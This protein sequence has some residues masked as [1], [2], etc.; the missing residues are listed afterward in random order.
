M[1]LILEDDKPVNPTQISLFSTV[2]EMIYANY[3]TNMVCA[4]FCHNLLIFYY[5]ENIYFV[6]LLYNRL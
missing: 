4:S 5:A 1:S 3:F 6:D 2:A